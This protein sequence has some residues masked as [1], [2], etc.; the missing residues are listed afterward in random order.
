MT[1]VVDEVST[2]SLDEVRKLISRLNSFVGDISSNRLAAAERV[3]LARVA[4]IAD[5]YE[6]ASSEAETKTARM[7]AL[8]REREELVASVARLEAVDLDPG[9]M[10][11]R[12]NG[13]LWQ[14]LGRDNLR[15]KPSNW[16]P[17]QGH[18]TTDP[19]SVPSANEHCK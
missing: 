18:V 15:F 5:D 16:L 17:R 2:V 6:V 11:D 3:E 19:S 9:P 1:S 12:L 7:K 10:A 13:D 8:A 14:L 4:A